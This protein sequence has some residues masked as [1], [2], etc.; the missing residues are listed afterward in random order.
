VSIFN[1]TPKE[2][3]S[4]RTTT[5]AKAKI[6]YRKTAIQTLR[7]IATKLE[8]GELGVDT[9]GLWPGVEGR[10]NFKIVLTESEIPVPSEQFKEE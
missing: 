3:K 2:G 7:A 6:R 5:S 1:R 10:W 4:A 9:F 8:K